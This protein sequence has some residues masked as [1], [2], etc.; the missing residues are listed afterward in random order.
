LSPLA[1]RL[2]AWYT[3]VSYGRLLGE[4]AAM[5][6]RPEEA[7]SCYQVALD[8]CQKVRFRPEIALIHLDLAQLTND[9]YPDE[10]AAAFGHQQF[11]AAKFGAMHMQ[12][13][14]DGSSDPGCRDAPTRRCGIA[15]HGLK[16]SKQASN[17]RAI[18]V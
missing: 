17:P 9:Y 12:P 6:G 11:A 10:R 18:T 3:I 13:S 4:A 5:L 16:G 15:E 1:G 2:Q 7:R 8:M 14:L